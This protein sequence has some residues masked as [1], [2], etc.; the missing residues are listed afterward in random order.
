MDVAA[1]RARR[2][3]SNRPRRRRRRVGSVELLQQAVV[4]L[5]ASDVQLEHGHGQSNIRANS[6]VTR[7]GAVIHQ[8]GD[9]QDDGEEH[10]GGDHREHPGRDELTASTGSILPTT[11]SQVPFHAKARYTMQGTRPI[12]APT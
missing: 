2:R 9:R 10:G 5:V 12:S 6:G 4:K 8:F 7:A 3:S 1:R 11:I